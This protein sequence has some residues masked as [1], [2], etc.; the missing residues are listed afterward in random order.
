MRLNEIP[1]QYLKIGIYGYYDNIID[2]DFKFLIVGLK[3][4]S[5]IMKYLDE[6]YNRGF[7][8][9]SE[10]YNLFIPCKQLFFRKVIC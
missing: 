10:G 4:D 5:F 6:A 2:I 9:I 1:I 3:E 8:S 7:I